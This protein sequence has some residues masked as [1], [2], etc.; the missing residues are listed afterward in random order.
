MPRAFIALDSTSVSG[1]VF[2]RDDKSAGFQL[3]RCRVTDLPRL[4]QLLAGVALAQLFLKSV[5]TRVLL[6]GRRRTIDPHHG[7]PGSSLL[8]LGARQVR[9][10]ILQGRAPR[11]EI[12]IL[13]GGHR[14]RIAFDDPP[15][16]R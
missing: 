15:V 9:Q 16:L 2:F 4:D 6:E 7:E 12:A 5:G 3:E 13:T 8:Q 14:P 1:R 11:V 10:H